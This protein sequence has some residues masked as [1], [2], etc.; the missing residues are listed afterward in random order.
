[1][2]PPPPAP[3][4]LPDLADPVPPPP[5]GGGEDEDDPKEKNPAI[6]LPLPLLLAIILLTENPY[7][8]WVQ[9]FLLFLRMFI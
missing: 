5:P 9:P 3:D 7:Q 2:G 1:M 6:A 8:K 4:L